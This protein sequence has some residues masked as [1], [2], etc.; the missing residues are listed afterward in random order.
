[1]KINQSNR[2]QNINFG[3]AIHLKTNSHEVLEAIE[4]ADLS[5]RGLPNPS[6]R[7]ARTSGQQLEK[8]SFIHGILCNGEE[9]D[10]LHSLYK[11][12][13]K[14]IEIPGT[15]VYSLAFLLNLSKNVKEV[16]VSSVEELK[17]LPMF[18]VI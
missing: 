12:D 7:F 2:Q 3:A 1:M 13:L 8:D 6:F 10:A 11:L 5:W 14:N 18:K 15:P 4:Y 17:N 16:V 9:K